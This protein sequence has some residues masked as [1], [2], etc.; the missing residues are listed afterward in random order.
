MLRLVV[1]CELTDVSEVLAASIYRATALMTEVVT[2]SETSINFY[3]TT[4]RN[5]PE[6]SH[7]HA[8][9]RED[10]NLTKY[11]APHYAVFSSHPSLLPSYVLC[12]L[13]S[14]TLDLVRSLTVC[15]MI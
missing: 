9:R 11:E 3:Q 1:W 13:F 12:T 14:D 2:S 8:R 7:I 5:M 4:W 6:D 10:L 15:T